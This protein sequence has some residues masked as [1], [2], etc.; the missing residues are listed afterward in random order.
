MFKNTF[1]LLFCFLASLSKC[2]SISLHRTNNNLELSNQKSKMNI[3]LNSFSL[4]SDDII[5]IDNDR[6]N[7]QNLASNMENAVRIWNTR[8]NGILSCSYGNHLKST[9]SSVKFD[10][11]INLTKMNVMGSMD[12]AKEA[13]FGLS[14]QSTFLKEILKQGIVENRSFILS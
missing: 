7:C 5:L 4:N 14:P 13:V 1:V 9:Y 10:S 12:G 2:T 11:S 3:Q 8:S 6:E